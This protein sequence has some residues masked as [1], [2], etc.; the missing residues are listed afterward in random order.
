M[1][2]GNLL[3]FFLQRDH[4]SMN[5]LF[6]TVSNVIITLKNK[7]LIGQGNPFLFLFVEYIY[8]FFIIIY[9]V[10]IIDY[11]ALIFFKNSFCYFTFY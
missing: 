6:E 1:S 5:E 11:K 10:F 4:E 7:S 8:I 3:F 9:L 2:Y